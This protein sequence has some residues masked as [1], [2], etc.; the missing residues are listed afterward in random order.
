[1]RRN[2]IGNRFTVSEMW[3][4]YMNETCSEGMMIESLD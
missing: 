4:F 2:E 3:M 1:M